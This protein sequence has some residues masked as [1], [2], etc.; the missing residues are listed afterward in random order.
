MIMVP[1]AAATASAIGLDLELTGREAKAPRS[2]ATT[3]MRIASML[4]AVTIT[5]IAV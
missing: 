1:T 3:I 5:P 4:I 2:T